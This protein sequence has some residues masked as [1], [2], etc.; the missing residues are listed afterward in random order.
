M[1]LLVLLAKKFDS[2]DCVYRPR[3]QLSFT[4]NC[5]QLVSQNSKPKLGVRDAWHLPASGVMHRALCVVIPERN[6]RHSR[7]YLSGSYEY[8]DG[9]K[10]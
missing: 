1:V 5:K 8:G 10:L 7:T 2:A 4:L 6:S 3:V 9:V